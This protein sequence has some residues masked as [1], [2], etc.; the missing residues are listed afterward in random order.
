MSKDRNS[1]YP[2]GENS[3]PDDWKYSFNINDITTQMVPSIN[4]SLTERQLQGFPIEV[5]D[6]NGSYWIN[7]SQSSNRNRPS[8]VSIEQTLKH[9]VQVDMIPQREC[10]I[11]LLRPVIPHRILDQLHFEYSR[12]GQWVL[13]LTRRLPTEKNL[14]Y[15]YNLMFVLQNALNTK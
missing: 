11:L 1:L 9:I 10:R 4:Q 15:I 12:N 7:C 14:M 6:I 13:N 3:L 8:Q 5:T 2:L